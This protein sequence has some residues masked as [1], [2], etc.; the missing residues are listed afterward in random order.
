MQ[1]EDYMSIHSLE[2]AQSLAKALR[3]WL[4]H[5]EDRISDPTVSG[6]MLQL[7]RSEHERCQ[8]ILTGAE[9]YLVKWGG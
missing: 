5:L 8:K 2:A 9:E 4:A 1:F 6:V 3:P 7:H